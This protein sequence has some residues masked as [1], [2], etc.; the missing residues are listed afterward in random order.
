[1]IS[2]LVIK[3]V[4]TF[5]NHCK[6]IDNLKNIN[7]FFGYNGTGKSTIV[8]YLQNLLKNENTIDFNDCSQVGY[9]SKKHQI[10][11]FNDIFINDNFIQN[12]ILNGIF[13]FNETND[14][15]DKQIIFYNQQIKEYEERIK[16]IENKNNILNNKQKKENEELL[17]YC[18]DF[19]NNFD[20]FSKI[21]LE[22]SGR[23][24]DH[25]NRIRKELQNGIVEVIDINQLSNKYKIIFENDIKEIPISI[26]VENYKNIRKTEHEISILLGEIIIGNEDVNIANLIKTLDNRKWVEDG[27]EY[28]KFSKNICPFCQKQTIDNDLQEQFTKYFGDTYKKRIEKIK[29]LSS[30]YISFSKQFLLRL[31]EIA[32]IYNKNNIISNELGELKNIFDNN[33]NIIN[34]KLM[35][36]NEKKKIISIFTQKKT[37]SVIIKNIKEENN[38]Y[39]AQDENKNILIKMIW[40]YISYHCAFYINNFDLRNEKYKKIEKSSLRVI[41]L[42]KNKIND[43]TLQIEGLRGQTVNTE[44]A[45]ININNILKN[46]GFDG[47]EIKEINRSNNISKY[48]IK[49]INSNSQEIFKTLSEGEKNFISFLYFH[50]LCIG[51]DDIKNN[52][53]KKIIIIDD[54]VSSLD[55]QALFIVSTLIRDLMEKDI[56][57]KG[58]LNTN[59]EQIFLFTHNVYFYKEVSYDRFICNDLCHYQVY[60]NKNISYVKN[61]GKSKINDDY[62]LLWE[63]LKE[64]KNNQNNDKSIN[65][66][67]SN[68]MRRIIESYINFIGIKENSWGILNNKSKNDP[69]Y[70]I[71]FGF[72]S[73]INEE[74][75]KLGVFDAVYYQR[76]ST[77]EPNIIFDIFKNIFKEIGKEHYEKMFGEI[78][79]NDDNT[80]FEAIYENIK[81]DKNIEIDLPKTSTK[82][83]TKNVESTSQYELF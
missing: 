12:D 65:I 56:K 61:N 7:F 1:M 79:E 52:N 62:S 19:R 54:P 20:T 24:A 6:P 22:H 66:L 15:I 83:I 55:S 47:F 4:A 60:K 76:L 8:R 35:K 38:I 23:R 50:Q 73:L 13:S 32:N 51:S 81:V 78:I 44:V 82:L 46:A 71:W 67:I 64:I 53:K 21:N 27:T 68:A 42:Y 69:N 39:K 45:V 25:L 63:S 9:D 74:S 5:D 16:S 14:E 29:A 43:I 3:N 70:F 40:S 30:Q 34:E 58:F 10:I 11:V 26:S 36:P 49:R 75:H 17:K 31:Q 33:T 57:K 18:W 28:L 2:S 37:L 77:V 48:Q 59:I 72:I 41:E 80:P